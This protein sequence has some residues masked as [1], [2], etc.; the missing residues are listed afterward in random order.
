LHKTK[1]CDIIEV[2][3]NDIKLQITSRVTGIEKGAGYM[4]DDD[5][6]KKWQEHI[7]KY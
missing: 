1:K 7:Q 4:A 6:E 5:R 2:L 3:K